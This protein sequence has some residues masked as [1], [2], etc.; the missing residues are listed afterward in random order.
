MKKKQVIGLVAAAAIF[1]LI[2]AAGLASGTTLR[3]A[4]TGTGSS[5]KEPENNIALISIT[6]T[7][8]PT[9]Y[10]AFGNISSSYVHNRI[11][12]NIKDMTESEENKGI[13]LYMDS[14]GGS[15]FE[16]DEV[17]VALMAYKEKTGRPVVAYAHKQMASGA[18]YIASAADKIYA[19]R[20]SNVGSIGVYIQALNYEELFQKLGVE[21]DYIKSGDNKAMGNPYESLTEEQ[22]AIY[23]GIV[24]ECY[25]QFLE[26]V[27]SAR[28]YSREELEPIA[29]GRIYTAKQSLEN[30]L[31]DEIGVFE[32]FLETF[33]KDCGAD[34]VY[35]RT[36]TTNTLLSFLGMLSKAQPK[37]ETEQAVAFLESMESGVPMYYYVG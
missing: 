31:I 27:M 24:D 8:G 34:V 18:Y 17:Y 32:T 30:G 10:D 19:N 28:G 9:T 2:A 21:S 22:R 20:N 25:D 15:V 3:N 35:Q 13:F 7:I 4:V 29:D 16:S 6:G 5:A 33:Q 1:V 26:V 36:Y 12:N 14:P 37:T 11:L 23:Q